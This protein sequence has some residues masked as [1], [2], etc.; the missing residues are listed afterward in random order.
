[1]ERGCIACISKTG[2]VLGECTGDAARG[3]WGYA[4][5]RRLSAVFAR[6]SGASGIVQAT[7]RQRRTAKTVRLRLSRLGLP[8]D[9]ESIRVTASLIAREPQVEIATEN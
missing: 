5:V 2:T 9:S 6:P 4:T 1:L 8:F 3:K 7:P